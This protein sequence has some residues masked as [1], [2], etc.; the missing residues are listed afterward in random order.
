M[1]PIIIFA[2]VVV[3]M[4]LI[5]YG[6]GIITEQVKHRVN[7]FILMFLALGLTFDLIALFVWS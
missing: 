2:I 3:H 7:R 6:I 1:K 4:A 5:S